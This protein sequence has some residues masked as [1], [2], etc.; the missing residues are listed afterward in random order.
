MVTLTLRPNAEGQYHELVEVPNSGFIWGDQFD[1]N[2]FT[3]WTSTSTTGTGVLVTQLT[4]KHHGNYAA[5]A[6]GTGTAGFTARCQKTLANPTTIYYRLYVYIDSIG[7]TNYLYFM[8]GRDTG[9]TYKFRLG[10]RGGTGARPLYLTY[11]KDG[12]LTHVTSATTLSLDTWYCIEVKCVVSATVGEIRVYKD[13]SEVND[14]T[15]TD[16]NNSYYTLNINNVLAGIDSSYTATEVIVD[17]VVVSAA[18]IGVENRSALVNDQDDNTA[19]QIASYAGETIAA[20]ARKTMY[21]LADSADLGTINSVTAYVRAK[22]VAGGGDEGLK[23]LWRLGATEIESAEKTPAAAY[24]D[25]SDVRN[26][27]PDGGA[28]SWADVNSLQIG[29]RASTL[30]NAEQLNFSELWIVVDY[31]VVGGLSIPVAMHHYRMM[32]MRNR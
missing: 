28:W 16:I 7:T 23:I 15:Q 21:N 11:M 12:S 20:T 24:S 29:V 32:R 27:D 4:I 22:Y 17:C 19:V 3:A 1:S 2:D 10:V 26:T 5:N 6:S 30:A 13:G 14:L 8:S 9:A 25:H 18:Y 31:T